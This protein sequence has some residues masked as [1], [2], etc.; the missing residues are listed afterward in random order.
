MEPHDIGSSDDDTAFYEVGSHPGSIIEGPSSSWV[1]GREIAPDSLPDAL[2]PGAPSSPIADAPWL[3]SAHDAP[4]DVETSH[5]PSPI[6]V[7]ASS[8]ASTRDAMLDVEESG[9]QPSTEE[10]HTPDPAA[11]SN[12]N[13]LHE[14]E[15]ALA[16]TRS[17]PVLSPTNR[18]SRLRNRTS[19]VS[20]I[21]D[22]ASDASHEEEGENSAFDKCSVASESESDNES[23]A[24]DSSP[25]SDTS[26]DATFATETEDI[27]EPSRV[28]P[29]TKR[30]ATART[31]PRETGVELSLPP[32]SK[33]DDILMDMTR[34]ALDLGLEEALDWLG[35]RPI[36]IGTMCSGT[37]S[38]V[39][40]LYAA[41]KSLEKLGKPSIRVQHRFSAE[42]EEFKQAFIERN[43]QPRLLFRDVREFIPNDARTA[44]TAYGAE[45]EIPGDL[46][47]LV[48]GFVCR[49]LSI[50]N[51]NKKSVKADGETG[52]TWRAIHS[53][54]KRFRPKIVLLE[55]VKATTHLWDTD[56]KQEWDRIGYSFTWAYFDTKHYYLPQT[57]QRMYMIAIDDAHFGKDG[58]KIL[59][60]WKDV[61]T[62]LR[63]PC[64]S[65]FE[66]FLSSDKSEPQ[67][68]NVANKEPDWRLS[69]LRLDLIRSVEN[70]GTKR[71]ITNWNDSGMIR[72]PDFANRTFYHSQSPRVWECI[73]VAAL[74][75][76]K[77]DYDALYKSMIWDVSQNADRFNTPFGIVSCITPGGINFVSNR[78]TPLTGS[79]LLLLQGMPLEKL[80]FGKET[81]KE[82]QDLAGNQM[83]VPVIG[84]SI[85]AALIASGKL[86]RKK[87]PQQ[88][89]LLDLNR[90]KT[91]NLTVI[92]PTRTIELFPSDSMSIDLE[93]LISDA[94][95]SSRLCRC[96]G[97]TTISKVTIQ[98]CQHCSHTSCT[99]CAGNPAH[100]YTSMI[101]RDDRPQ[102]PSDFQKKWRPRLPARLRFH[103]FPD[104]TSL[105]KDVGHVINQNWEKLLG[106]IDQVDL[107]A[108][109]FCIA[110]FERM[111][112]RWKVSY[113]SPAA[114]LEL[115]IDEK[116][117]WLIY[118]RCPVSEPGNSSFRKHIA[119]PFA[120]GVV[121]SSLLDSD[122]AWEIRIPKHQTRQLKLTAS[123]ESTSGW[124]NQMGLPQYKEEK[125]PLDIRISCGSDDSLSGTY[126]ALKKCGTAKNSLYKR[127][128]D[129]PLYM[130]LDP[131]PIGAV[132]L[133]SF[134]FSEDCSRLPI[135]QARIIVGNL[136][137]S[138]RPWGL[139]HGEA[140]QLFRVT[141]PGF[142]ISQRI[143][144]EIAVPSLSITTPTSE[145]LITLRGSGC[146][147]AVTI[148]DVQIK[149]AL[150]IQTMSQYTWVL[151]RA[152]G[153]PSFS[154]WQKFQTACLDK[155]SEC[156]C[157][158]ALPRILWSVDDKGEASAREERQ[159]ASLFERKI[160]KRC[161]IVNIKP[162]V[163]S[164]GT[165]IRVGINMVS[166]AHQA[167]SRLGH[168]ADKCMWRL[169]TDDMTSA[170]HRFPKFKIQSNALDVPEE[171][172]L[173]LKYELHV[174]QK[175]S[176]QWMKSQEI[177]NAL[178]IAEIEEAIHPELGWRVEAKAETTHNVRGG[179]LAD[180]PSFGKTV[181]TIA[182]IDSEFQATSPE[183]LLLQHSKLEDETS[184]L[185]KVPATLVICPAH[186]AKQW[187]D[188]FVS[189]LG[190]NTSDEYNI[191]LLEKYSDLCAYTMEDFR[192]A[193]VV[194]ASWTVLADEE[195][196]QQLAHFSGVP[197]PVVLKGRA[198]EAWL[199]YVVNHMSEQVCMF[200]SQPNDFDKHTEQLLKDRLASHDF[201]QMVPLKISHGSQYKSF[202]AMRKAA[203]KKGP[204]L[205]K[206][207]SMLEASS[208]AIPLLHMFNFNRLVIDEYHYLN[209]SDNL[210]ACSTVKRISALKRWVLSGTPALT[211]FSDVN[212]IAAFLGVRLGRDV[213][214]DGI[215]TT[216]FEKKL[217]VER[218]DVEKFLSYTE[219]MSYKWH[220]ARHKRAQAFLDTFV[221][222]NEPELQDIKCDEVLRPVELGLVH[223]VVYL[224][225][226]QHLI[227]QRMQIK[228]LEKKSGADRPER[229]NA[230]L[231]NSVTAEEA[232]LKTAL[233]LKAEGGAGLDQLIS[234]RRDQRKRTEIDFSRRAAKL[235]DQCLKKLKDESED[236]YTTIRNGVTKYNQLQDTEAC[237]IVC[238]ILDSIDRTAN[239]STLRRTKK[240]STVAIKK[241]LKELASDVR[242]IASELTSRIR[243]ERFL[244]TIKELLPI[245][246][247]TGAYKCNSPSCLGTDDP[248]ELFV[249]SYCGHKAC[250]T[251]LQARLN[252][253]A[254]VYDGCEVPVHA[255]NLIKFSDIGS[256]T[257]AGSTE[258]YSHGRKLD[259]IC[260][261]LK[262]LPNDEQAIVFVPNEEI[263][264]IMEKVLETEEMRFHSLSSRKGQA[265]IELEDFKSDRDLETMSKVLI[266]NLMSE[267]AAGANLINAN[268]V[269]FVSPL[270][271]KSQYG[272][273]S[274]M[275]Q[276]IA[277][278]RRYGQKKK[279]HIY[280][281]AA[282]S[283]IDIDILEHRHKRLDVLRS[284][285]SIIK[286]PTKFRGS[287]EKVKTRMV[288][289]A[290]GTM[291]LV[292]VPWLVDETARESIRVKEVERFTSLINFSETFENDE[293]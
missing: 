11:T 200:Q 38:P 102:T 159:A 128:S 134:V 17:G 270:L 217:A 27:V 261:L 189:C 173:R 221:R 203:L 138:F 152:K 7:D 43:F 232:L 244:N 289:T 16:V 63:R 282:L 28:A 92:Q 75:A 275:A 276:A 181:T 55:N 85:Y 263:V 104:T 274:S 20:Y 214:G 129:P 247:G 41:S 153:L 25:G 235:K 242:S 42:I 88:M 60:T 59:E 10:M 165:S 174:A 29:K 186:L 182:L 219:V 162:A 279:V 103:T 69:K 4:I 58:R 97:T 40:F 234:K 136:E 13:R 6:S 118:L 131:D 145:T 74:Q 198:F 191:L 283:T 220:E 164:S 107:A 82:L 39:V 215:I 9:A 245:L 94:R 267:S 80:V 272:Y 15:P 265:A 251:C 142:W 73:D 22:S 257:N 154:Q 36:N 213:C 222:Q 168:N 31:V 236:H 268:H 273:E 61:M 286:M 248:T 110:S 116:I 35:D 255:H 196:V 183:T 176:L 130:F 64:S 288:R 21:L 243:S 106:L 65:P 166:L 210:S 280:H 18:L 137:S 218:T 185:I 190:K 211:N 125:M 253:E 292:P 95:F 167:M 72:P 252:D 229:L 24:V 147:E 19:R 240:E 224:E 146:S 86:L 212:Q 256:T 148:L 23:M 195:Y 143:S 109:H 30:K 54:T 278:C 206:R 194:I 46:D 233:Y 179:V 132:N 201:N 151:E 49:D 262:T 83:S 98:I 237:R 216:D 124:R 246:E 91:T 120:R 51:R 260:Y 78:Q 99:H 204:K 202:E 121:K 53:Y 230:S 258:R 100:S 47:L 50:L 149:E 135:D 178:T 172:P 90:Q 14:L 33:F 123:N 44:T 150:R 87:T 56:I 207:G 281:F 291:A 81:P 284:P 122:V 199:D 187:M 170:M 117:R 287:K 111:D 133:D 32:M 238:N 264:G 45:E 290:N 271:S 52:D 68:Y 108:Q 66:S 197:P 171:K 5:A 177:G 76:G 241:E 101:T 37:E 163:S 226:S 112:G 57:R 155:E 105:K 79:Q 127:S 84:A 26:S 266:L 71:P 126:C 175:K 184:S 158:P 227:S 113:R 141:I 205:M 180:L 34:N 62:Q 2:V 293:D 96:E 139:K 12:E 259:E 254:C 239:P 209:L 192:A 93:E 70:L 67:E 250:Q 225:I 188:E 285:G 228:R 77:R 89:Q 3:S 1:C 140:K 249:I 114:D 169:I 160:K 157:S 161:P 231:M 119:Q 115:Q 144:L 277:R 193:R 269:I 208:R 223:R 156:Q 48:A 8:S